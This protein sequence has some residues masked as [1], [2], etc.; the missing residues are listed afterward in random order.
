MKNLVGKK[1]HESKIPIQQ[2]YGLYAM[3]RLVLKL[4]ETEFADNL[5]VKGG[6]L[7]TTDLGVS[8][9][10][11]R[12]LDFTL[13]NFSLD[14]DTINELLNIIEAREENDGE[15]FEF[16]S[17]D[18]T[19]DD[20]EYNGYNLKLIYCNGNTK[21]PIN[22]D[23]TS[24]E[25]IIAIQ[26]NKRF[27]SIFT[28]E[29]YMLNSY[30]MEQVISDKLYTLLAYGSIDD[31]NSRMKDYY[32]LYLLTRINDNLDL[33]KINLSLEKT[34]KQR[35]NYIETEDYEEII[36]YLSDSENQKGLWSRY[37]SKSSYAASIEFEEVMN[38]IHCFSNELVQQKL[39]KRKQKN[40]STNNGFE[41]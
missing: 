31:T 25:D 23:V 8:M 27:K 1:A 18:E 26:R 41:L 36:D 6:F 12:D 4:S 29:E 14:E 16:N 24:G 11:T 22:V 33:N 38:E 7:L 34:M 28:D 5:I 15:H 40:L 21:I 10:S 19:R 2:M 37:V 32:D 39:K 35:E 20:F 9:R 30:P 17:I 13:E 3:D